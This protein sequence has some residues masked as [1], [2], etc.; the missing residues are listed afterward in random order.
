MRKVSRPLLRLAVVV[1]AA[2]V[3]GSF[4]GDGGAGVLSAAQNAIV[5]ENMVP[6]ATDWD[7][8]GGNDP[9][10]Q[11]FA[12]D[13]SI[14]I[15]Q[16]VNF[17]I[18]T[19]ATNYR[20]DIY[21]LGYYGGDGARKIT[22]TV[23]SLTNPQVQ[24][25]C[26]SDVTTGL[27]DCGNWAVSASWTAVPEIG[28]PPI[29]S[30]IYLAKLTRINTGVPAT[31]ASHIVF[32]VRDDTRHSD[33]LFQTSDTTWQAY[34]SY[35]GHSLYCGGPGA[36]PP[37]Y[38]AQGRSYKVSYNR[39]FNTRDTAPQSWLFNAEY[40]MVRWLEANGYDVSYFTG[41]DSDRSG[42]EIKNHKAFLSVGH[43]EYWS[44]GQRTNVEAARDA[45]V[46]LA[47]FSGDELFWKTR[48]EASIDV[49]NTP[50]RTLVSYKETLNDAKIDT[51]STAWTGT[52]RDPRA[53]TLASDGGR[54]ENATTGTMWTVNCCAS[55]ISVPAEM[56]AHRFWRNTTVAAQSPGS[57]ATLIANSL[58]YEWDEDLD[59]GFRP[60]GLVRLSSTIV[61]VPEKLLSDPPYAVGP[62]TATHSLTLYR[63]NTLDLQGNVKSSALVFG[64]GTVQWSW[65]LDGNRGVST[66]DPRM[67]QATV[68]LFADMGV[69]PGSIQ[70]GL[71][72]A[73]ASSDTVAP[74]STITSP[75]NG[76]TAEGGGRVTIGGTATDLGGGV[77]AGVEVS[78]DGGATWHPAKGTSNWTYD[79]SPGTP[80]A[81]TIQ[82]RATDD[83]GNVEVATSGVL[84][85]VVGSSCPCN[86]LWNPA[87]VPANPD[88]GDA[89]GVEVGVRFSSDIAGF[90]T[91][92]RF[93]KS[94]RNT[95]THI[96]NLWANTVSHRHFHERDRCRLAA[97]VIPYSS[98]DRRE[99]DLRGLVSHQRGP[100]CVRHRV[101]RDRGRQFPTAPRA[102]LRRDPQWCLRLRRERV[103]HSVV[104]CGQLLGR[105]QLRA[106]DRRPGRAD[107]FWHKRQRHRRI[108]RDRDLEN[109]CERRLARRLFHRSDLPA[110]PDI[111][112]AERRARHR[113]QPHADGFDAERDVLHPYHVDQRLW[114]IHDGLRAELHG[115]WS[116]LARHGIG[117]L[118]RRDA[119]RQYVCL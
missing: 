23:I 98:A 73:S 5:S 42:A 22:S 39:P 60:A 116:D 29:T 43:D 51:S 113:P 36:N 27:I 85:T 62:A 64:A 75:T 99:Y 106:V 54:P 12:T 115:A 31:A 8:A 81:V 47:F 80:G 16:T 110:G 24:P 20:I 26:A 37:S 38:C 46:H 59:N 55:A 107:H 101:L 13:I 53:K 108:Q 88:S 105:C 21:R 83:S 114:Q 112:R 119:G 93:Y 74:S 41:V 91:G 82:S 19:D 118:P 71:N 15:G 69:Q 18:N 28:A 40:P 94:L 72:P 3:F 52:W 6:G 103:P 33:L 56:G 86:H 9:T 10:I 70:T 11:G 109:G 90:L 65:G 61:D 66:P 45:G 78:A 49:A 96:G 79:W 117:R 77:V 1:I 102:D 32:V 44:A 76:A 48:W 84:V 35:G 50:Y 89:S 17:K 34:N 14:A 111:R 87:A 97:G 104:P 4:R 92:I 7:L 67:Q 30:G 2:S 100:L 58:G 68:N 57:V 95:G 25:D 63:K